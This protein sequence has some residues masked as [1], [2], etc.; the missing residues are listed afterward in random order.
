M[1]P[2]IGIIGRNDMSYLNK[3]T[4]CVFDNY[5]KAVI[6]S[7]GNPILILPPQQVDYY[8]LSQKD[9]KKLSDIEKQMIIDQLNLCSG[10]IMPGGV[11]RF[12]YDDFICE[13]CNKKNIPLLGICMGMQIMCN[14]N[15]DN[16]NIKITEHFEVT[17]KV[18][19][20]K[21]SKLY[22]I[23]NK[24]NINV[25]SLHNYKVL[26]SGSYKV[27][28]T[29]GDVIEAIEK[30]NPFNMGFQWHPEK[31]YDTD[32]ASKKIFD[33]FIKSSISKKP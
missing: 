14:Y 2:I 6:N 33:A 18:K 1:R 8:N 19:I 15:N 7:G 22:K 30:E 5:R 3:S 10:I 26:N 16:K 4:I 31:N 11:K 23:L 32:L 29:C 9:I 12:E 21:N 17:H 24:T 13:Y 28:A 27:S 25:N 20:N